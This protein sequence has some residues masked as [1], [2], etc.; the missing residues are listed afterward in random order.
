MYRSYDVILCNN[1]HGSLFFYFQNIQI[2]W[3]KSETVRFLSEKDN[4]PV[5]LITFLI[6]LEEVELVIYPGPSDTCIYVQ[7]SI[8]K[9]VIE[10]LDGGNTFRYYVSEQKN[11][12]S[13]LESISLIKHPLEY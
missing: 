11:S 12:G 7:S 6:G 9:G 5:E 10:S 13:G 2:L 3:E 8:G 4:S 1:G